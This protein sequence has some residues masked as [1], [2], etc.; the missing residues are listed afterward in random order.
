MERSA[1]GAIGNDAA[2]ALS[3]T[4][5]DECSAMAWAGWQAAR[6]AAGAAPAESAAAA[7][8]A[9]AWAVVAA[10]EPSIRNK[11]RRGRRLRVC[12]CRENGEYGGG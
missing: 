7:G 12:A 3:A 6:E 10:S 1:A 11:W 2:E 8:G 4:A 5:D 9:A